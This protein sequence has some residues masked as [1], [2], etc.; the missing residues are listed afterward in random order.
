MLKPTSIPGIIV[1]IT[2]A[3]LL[4]NA[5]AHAQTPTKPVPAKASVKAAKP[6]AAKDA[7]PAPNMVVISP[8]LVTSGQPNSDQLGNLA[9]QGFEAVIYLAP[10]WVS[11]AILDEAQ[12]IG[13]Q[14]MVNVNIP[15]KFDNPTEKD[16]ETFAAVLQALGKRKVLVHCQVNMRASSM[17]FLYRSIILKEDP[18][19]AWESVIKIWVPEGPW[20]KLIQQQLQKHQIKFEPF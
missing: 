3:L 6:E 8:Q 1:P 11:D 2:L 7:G 10:P 18:Q 19:A 16:F 12:I 15:I 17:V 9:A 13:R 20:K 5:H 4:A 14:G